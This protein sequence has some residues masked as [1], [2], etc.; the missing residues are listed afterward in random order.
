MNPVTPK[1]ITGDGFVGGIAELQAHFYDCATNRQADQYV[2]T[3]KQIVEHIGRTYKNGGDIRATLD[4]GALFQILKPEDPSD[5][6][7]D[8]LTSTGKVI[9]TARQQIPYVEDEIFKQEINN[10]VRR[11][12]QLSANVQ[13]AYSLV[14]GQCTE[15]MKNKLQS[16]TNWEN[17]SRKQD[18]ISLLE[19]I[20]AI[21]FCFEH[22][23]YQILSIFN[24]KSSFYT[25]RQGSMTNIAYLQSFSNLAEIAT[26]L[27]GNLH[28]DAIS[29]IVVLELF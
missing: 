2:N 28:D 25:F 5:G 26:S 29:S 16:S 9:K 13:Q 27:G 3:T 7:Q 8:L 19:E 20:K 17:I 4:E 23:K 21:T 6:Y 24:A 15:M 11:K 18:V 1:Q 10:Y 22:Q 14:L 12:N